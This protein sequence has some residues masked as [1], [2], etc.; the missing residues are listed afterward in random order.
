MSK[1]KAKRRSKDNTGTFIV[2]GIGAVIV[3]LGLILLGG[4]FAQPTAQASAESL[5]TCNG[6]PCPS[7]GDPGAPVTIIEVADYGCPACRSFALN[8]EPL[9]DEEFVAT[10]KVRFVSHLFGFG[11]PTQ[12]AAAAALCAGEQNKFW[13][14]NR[15]AFENQ[16]PDDAPGQDVLLSWG[17]QAGA[18]PSAFAECVRSGRYVFD[19]QAA[20]A[21]ARRAG[22][23]RTPSFFING[24]LLE[25]AYPIGDFRAEINRA[26]AGQ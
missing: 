7:K 26:L 14:F 18:E 2:V 12:A 23:S 19:V 15:V 9:I 10:G 8:T 20:S 4:G 22:V 3:A 6:K 1:A 13:E 21:E 11:A 25:G 17:Q 16:V 24:R 5:V